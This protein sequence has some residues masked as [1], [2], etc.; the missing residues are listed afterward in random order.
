MNDARRYT[1]MHWDMKT[2]WGAMRGE[3]AAEI[4]E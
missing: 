2:L 4:L 1:K 3:G